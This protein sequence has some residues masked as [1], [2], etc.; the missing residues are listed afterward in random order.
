[1]SKRQLKRRVSGPC[2]QAPNKCL[3]KSDKSRTGGEATK[4]RLRRPFW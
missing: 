4:E 1:M 2:E 3:A